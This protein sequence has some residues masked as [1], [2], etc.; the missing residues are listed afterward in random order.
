MKKKYERVN[1]TVLSFGKADI[2]TLSGFTGKDDEF[3]IEEETEE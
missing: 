2:L 1:V 3:E